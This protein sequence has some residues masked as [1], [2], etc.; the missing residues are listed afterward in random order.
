MNEKQQKGRSLFYDLEKMLEKFTEASPDIPILEK[1][2]VD[3]GIPYV[4]FAEGYN[5]LKETHNLGL[6]RGIFMGLGATFLGVLIPELLK[7]NGQWGRYLILTLSS[8]GVV[9]IIHYRFSKRKMD[10]FKALKTRLPSLA[11][12]TEDFMQ[13]LVDSPA[14]VEKGYAFESYSEGN[15]VRVYPQD[16]GTNK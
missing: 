6:F 16:T 11:A 9:F 3:V 5:I 13:K 14:M 10:E 8:F 15:F 7:D 2:K 12:L 4:D 1:E